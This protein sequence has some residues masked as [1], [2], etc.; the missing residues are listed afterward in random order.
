MKYI[1][2]EN[3]QEIKHNG[4]IVTKRLSNYIIH[5]D[6]YWCKT[7]SE[8]IFCIEHGIYEQPM[9]KQCKKETKYLSP[10]QGGYQTFCSRKCSNN[11]EE[12]IKKQKKNT[13]WESAGKKISGIMRG[14]T[15][16]EKQIISE[17]AMITKLERYGDKDF[18]N[19]EKF[20]ETCLEKYGFENP[21]QND[22]IKEKTKNTQYEK[23][24]GFFNPEQF[25]KTNLEK[26]GCEYPLQNKEYAKEFS[27][28]LRKK[29]NSMKKGSGYVYII[30]FKNINLV[31]I[32]YT[33]NIEKRKRLLNKDFGEFRVIE[34]TYF[35]EAYKQEAYL[36]DLYDHYNIIL[37]EG[38]GRTEF[39][40]PDII[41]LLTSTHSIN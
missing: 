34:L 40:L 11:D 12:V 8:S 22:K 36:H 35:D 21:M 2:I 32:G 30:H 38:C 18:N 10:K 16:R 14:R 29:Y 9:C 33:S 17:K 37:D 19:R 3:V 28:I 6:F 26:Y 5:P 7:K 23:Y 39:F 27:K 25:I 13:D 1:T 41:P 24:G 15:T 20:K 31:K 4:K